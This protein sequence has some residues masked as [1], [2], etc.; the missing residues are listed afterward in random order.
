MTDPERL[1]VFVYGTLRP[2]HGNHGRFLRGRTVAEEPARMRGVVLFEGPGY[3]YAVTD[4]EG[5]VRGEVVWL[6]PDRYDAVLASL[7]VLEGYAPGGSANH[8][9]RVVRTAAPERGGTV[10]VWV[11]LA[12]ED[13]ARRLRLRGGRVPGNSWPG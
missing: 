6:A 11:Y 8:Y 7:D 10:R 12:S 1:P 4:P 5:E 2:G 13:V 9:V 3:P